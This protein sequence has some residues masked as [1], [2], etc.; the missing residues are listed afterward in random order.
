MSWVNFLITCGRCHGH[1]FAK[2]R[3]LGKQ[4]DGQDI[5]VIDQVTSKCPCDWGV[6]IPAGSKIELVEPPQGKLWEKSWKQHKPLKGTKLI[7]P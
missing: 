4:S 3:N 1:A 5:L 6:K 7:I 2:G